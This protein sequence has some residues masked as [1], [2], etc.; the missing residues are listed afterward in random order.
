MQVA[1]LLAAAH[2]AQMVRRAAEL[3]NWVPVRDASDEPEWM[4][5]PGRDRDSLTRTFRDLGRVNRWLGGVS[6]TVLALERLTPHLRPGDEIVILDV[7]TGSA[8]I[9]RS[10]ATWARRRGLNASIAATDINPEILSLAV[11]DTN[12]DTTLESIQFAA[13]DARS[14]PFAD[15][16]VDIAMCSFALHHLHPED[17]VRTLREMGRVARRGVIVNDLLRNRRGFLGAWVLSR[18][19]TR[20][21]ISRHDA[22]LSFRRGYTRAE[23]AH[24]ASQAGLAS[25]SFKGHLGYR[26][27]MVATKAAAPPL[28]D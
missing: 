16:S 2:P 12:P 20:N 3:T 19:F 1:G 21:A 5:L 10:V 22:L 27:A 28:S 4:D 8:D 6:L 15:Q 9:P 11:R 7:A 23:M 25:V 17:A 26:V 24:L 13:A 14:L 18:A